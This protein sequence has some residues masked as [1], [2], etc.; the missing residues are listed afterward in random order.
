MSYSELLTSLENIIIDKAATVP[1][2]RNRKTD[3]SAPM[4]IG[5]AAKEDGESA[6]EEEDERIVDLA[7]EA[8]YKELVKESGVLARV[9]VGMAKVAKV[10][11]MGGRTH[12]RK[13]V[14]RKEAKGTRKVEQDRTHCSVVQKGR[15]QNFVRHR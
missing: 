15:Q 8:V 7:L 14:A 6:S 11:K 2:A 9:R 5:T 13:A 4:E 3:T 10:A 12:G 1:T